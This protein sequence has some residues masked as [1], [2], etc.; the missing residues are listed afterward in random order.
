MKLLIFSSYTN[1]E[2]ERLRVTNTTPGI[3]E[4]R[5]VQRSAHLEF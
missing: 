1:S 4:L 3:I 2:K 5:L